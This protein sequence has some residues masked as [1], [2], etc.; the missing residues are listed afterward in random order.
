MEWRSVCVAP[1]V[2]PLQDANGD[3]AINAEDGSDVITVAFFPSSLG[4][5]SSD[6][7]CTEGGYYCDTARNECLPEWKS[8]RETTGR[9]VALDGETGTE[10][11]KSPEG[12][13]VCHSATPA[14]A[15]LDGDGVVE[16][17]T[18]VAS[19]SSAPDS[20]ASRC[21]GWFNAFLYPLSLDF[22]G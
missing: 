6:A 15:D 20:P 7:D 12:I 9:V 18:L 14:A 13:E 3:G 21:G 2:A 11:W 22:F 19:E 10:L 17:V 16:I 4:S 1:L 5:C 8:I